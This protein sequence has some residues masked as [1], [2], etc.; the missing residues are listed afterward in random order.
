FRRGTAA[1]RKQRRGDRV[2]SVVSKRSESDFGGD[3]DDEFN[4]AKIVNVEDTTKNI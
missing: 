4:T 3:D 1:R 2:R